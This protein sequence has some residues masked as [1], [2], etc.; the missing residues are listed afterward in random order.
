KN[1]TAPA[2]A[3]VIDATGKHVTAGLID[4][5][6]HTAISRGINEGSSAVTCE[7]RIGDVLDATDVGIYRELGGGLTVANVLHGSAN[8]MGG[9]NQV[10]KLRWGAG[11]E[12]LKFAGAK[13][14]VKFALGENVK[15]S[16]R[17]GTQS[18]TPPRYPQTRM[19]VEQVMADEFAQARD[20]MRA[21]DE[22][23]A[24]T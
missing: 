5:H 19:G 11:A 1:L 3:I 8:P 7:V 13:P 9:Q 18:A 24:G 15:Q 21:L 14:G 4:C 22:W 17:V 16:S 6:S 2:G 10:I 20:Y 23:K 12:E